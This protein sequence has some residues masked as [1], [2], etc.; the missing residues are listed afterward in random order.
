MRVSVTIPCRNEEAYI[1]KCLQSI[2]DCNYS[3][4]LIKVFVVDGM[5]EDGT[6]T[7]VRD[8]ESQ[9]SYISLLDNVK[10]VTPFALNI[11]L[12]SDDSEVKIILGA[13]ATVDKNFINHS[14]DTLRKDPSIGCA[15]GVIKNV[16]ENIVAETIG[17]AMSSPF[18]V[19]NAKFRTGGKD[20]YVDTVAFGAY[21]KEVFDKAG[22]F[23]EDLVRN[24][25]DEFNFR[26][27]KKGFKIWF[28]KSIVSNYYVRGSYPKLFRQYYQY[29]YWKVFVNVKHKAVTSVRQLVPLFFV[30]YLLAV[31]V[32]VILPQLFQ[33]IYA[34]GF[35]CYILGALLFSLRQTTK[36][37]TVFSVIKVFTILH[38]SYGFGYL[39]GL[40]RFVLRKEVPSSKS[41]K[42]SR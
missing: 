1:G 4:D 29:G 15:G 19:G 5:S 37:T 24:Q 34:T 6:R 14:V 42:T 40:Y 25:D 23:D 36:I 41:K 17:L 31:P 16:Y 11:G 26:I 39:I 3:K 28:D 8:F 10:K 33:L 12:K 2:V 18:G 27:G 7:I 30:L 20:G 22:Y 13:H 21:K 32:V 35:V 9:Y 38:F